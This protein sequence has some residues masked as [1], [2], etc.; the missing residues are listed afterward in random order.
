VAGGELA[1]GRGSEGA[2]GRGREGEKERG[3]EGAKE[4]GREGARK[5]EIE[6]PESEIFSLMLYAFRI[7]N[8]KANG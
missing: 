7:D 8:G 6:N 5:S 2:T 3:S 4:R 1:R